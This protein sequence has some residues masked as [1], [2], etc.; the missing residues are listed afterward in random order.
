M[1]DLASQLS[2]LLNSPDGMEKIKGLAAG[3]LGGKETEA[4]PPP[5]EPDEAHAPPG[6]GP[7]AETLKT[8][9]KFAPLLS[10]I[11]QE[12]DTTR[13]LHALRPLLS[14]PRRKK[15]DESVKLLQLMRVLPLLKGSGILD[16]F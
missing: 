10:G 5:P 13:F 1:A 16:L 7:D 9:M 4:D 3:L 14:E 11:R 8:V 6:P 12:D 2:E 15:L